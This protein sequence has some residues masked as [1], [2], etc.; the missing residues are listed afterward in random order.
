[1]FVEFSSELKTRWIETLYQELMLY[2][3]PFE[4]SG[5]R[6]FSV[7]SVVF[8][9][10][11]LLLITL[12]ISSLLDISFE[13]IMLDSESYL[14]AAE[15]FC[16]LVNNLPD[17][18]I[19]KVLRK[20]DFLFSSLLEQ[21]IPRLLKCYGIILQ[22]LLVRSHSDS[23]ALSLKILKSISFIYFRRSGC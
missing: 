2:K 11:P 1:M 15:L 12:Y 3:P 22:G 10:S 4:I 16:S 9:S 19:L 18:G 6:K 23:F 20:F 7:I 13:L 21:Q 5:I 17:S 14:S 8:S